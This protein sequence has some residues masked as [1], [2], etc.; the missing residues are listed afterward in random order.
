MLSPETGLAIPTI[1][2]GRGPRGY[3]E[4]SAAT[5]LRAHI[6]PRSNA[7]SAKHCSSSREGKGFR[8]HGRTQQSMNAMIA[9][10]VA[11]AAAGVVINLLSARLFGHNHHHDLN[12]RAAV[13][14]SAIALGLTGWLRLDA[15][16]AI[17]IRRSTLQLKHGV[18]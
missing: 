6:Q 7:V 16:T 5:H 4:A 3:P 15:I 17:G 18:H 12:Q 9:G 2:G 11:W 8:P 13:L 14:L 1:A 10:P